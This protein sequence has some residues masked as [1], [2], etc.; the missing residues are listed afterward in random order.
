VKVEINTSRKPKG[1]F[2]KAINVTSN[3]A[4]F[5]ATTLNCEAVIKVPYDMEPNII[6]FGTIERASAGETRTFKIKRGDGG[7]LN[8]E[9]EPV[10][11]ANLKLTLKEIT[12]GDEYDLEVQ[13]LPPWPASSVE[14][15]INFKTGVPESPDDKIRYYGR[16]AVRLRAAP[17]KIAV[18]PEL[19]ED[20]KMRVRM[21]WSGDKPG[22][23]VD[24]TATDPL[25]TGKFVEDQNE[26]YVDVLVPKTFK[27]SQ[28]G[29][30]VIVKTDDAEVPELRIQVVPSQASNAPEPVERPKGAI[31][32]QPI[33]RPRPSLSNTPNKASGDKPE[34]PEGQPVKPAISPKNPEQPKEKPAEA[35]PEKPPVD[36]EPIKP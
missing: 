15:Y 1:K 22:K 24:V 11:D 33:L 35:T 31:G 32:N 21:I 23:V 27:A 5:R 26:Q 2:T 3:D 12:A 30:F 4:N 8:P 36:K 25:I 34:K 18:Q 13:A 10:K 9:I 19:K 17:N 20:L 16:M 29:T 28:K 14:G 7:P 6:N